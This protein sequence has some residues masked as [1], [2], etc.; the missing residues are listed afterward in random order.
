MTDTATPVR[1]QSVSDRLLN[2]RHLTATRTASDMFAQA[3]LRVMNM[4]GSC[5]LVKSLRPKSSTI[6]GLSGE[7]VKRNKVSITITKKQL[8]MSDE[9]AMHAPGVG[10]VVN[11]RRSQS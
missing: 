10:G 1:L 7:T 9:F 11:H 2:G 6:R 5:A 4:S 8:S 3:N